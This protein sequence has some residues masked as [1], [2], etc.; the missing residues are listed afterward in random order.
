MNPATTLTFA[1]LGKIEAFDAALYIAAQ[2]IG[3]IAG[4]A[5]ASGLFPRL[6]RHETVRCVVTQPGKP[7]PGGLRLAFLGECAM[8]FVLFSVVLIATNHGSLAPYTPY[9]V[10]VLVALYITFEA[11]ISGM[12]MN[13]ART[14]GSALGARSYRALWIYFVAPPLGMLAAAG[15]Y[16]AALGSD[17]V[18]CCKLDHTGH[19]PCIFHCRI[20]QAPGRAA[21][22]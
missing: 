15:V 16:S 6:V 12:S 2:F 9:F 5:F 17:S 3:G 14:L 18:Y 22:R 10:G 21:T 4:V 7:G 13:P 8:T 20:D 11:P 1:A 19:Q